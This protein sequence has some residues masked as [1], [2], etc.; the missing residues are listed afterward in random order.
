MANDSSSLTKIEH[1]ARKFA[2]TIEGLLRAAVLV[3]RQT[4]EGIVR[5]VRDKH[6]KPFVRMHYVPKQGNWG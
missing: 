6:P 4:T 5:Y 1:E 3:Q 2:Q